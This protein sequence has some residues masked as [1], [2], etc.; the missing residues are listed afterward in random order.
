M[1]KRI[2]VK[3]KEEIISLFVN[4]ESINDLSSKFSCSKITITRHL[5]KNIEESEYKDLIRKNNNQNKQVD[6]N[7]SETEIIKSDDKR[8]KHMEESKIFE[9]FSSESFTEIMPLDIEVDTEIQKDLSSVPILDF[10]FPKMVYMIVDKKIELETKYLR[11]YPD[12]QFLSQEEL[13]R[14]TIQIFDDLKVAKRF[15]NKEQKVIKV[16]NTN[17]FKITAQILLNKGITRI[18]SSDQ[19]IAL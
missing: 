8:E 19:L 10:N 14:K 13:N 2:S 7:I 16:P 11:E 12:W 1:P 6:L 4:G 18:V 5:K 9:S 15:C 17:V 3:E